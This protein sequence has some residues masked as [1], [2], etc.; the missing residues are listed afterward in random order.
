MVWIKHKDDQVPRWAFLLHVAPLN[1]GIMVHMICFCVMSVKNPLFKIIQKNERGLSIVIQPRSWYTCTKI[2]YT[3]RGIYAKAWEAKFALNSFWNAKILR[4]QL[5]KSIW[6]TLLCMI[7][8]FPLQ[9]GYRFNKLELLLPQ[10][11]LYMQIKYQRLWYLIK[12]ELTQ[13]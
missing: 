9:A 12:T 1:L 11:I 7:R 2:I 3:L 6:W 13:N 5:W 4:N 10:Y 8:S